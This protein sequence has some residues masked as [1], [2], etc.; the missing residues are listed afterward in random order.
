MP[1]AA[2]NQPDSNLNDPITYKVA[3]RE[4]IVEP[5]YNEHAHESIGE[6]L[7]KIILNNVGE[8][9]KKG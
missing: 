9:L 1:Q 2:Q 3:G 5:V 7:L 8:K 4:F 6:I